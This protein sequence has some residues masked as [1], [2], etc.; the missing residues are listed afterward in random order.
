MTTL[1]LLAA[2]AAGPPNIVL[3]I[4]DDLGYGELS[5]DR[6]HPVETPHLSRLIDD[7]VYFTGGYV[8]APFCAASRA[9]L[10]TGRYQ[11]RFG[12]EFNPIGP[13]NERPGVGLPPAEV[14]IPEML[15]R[16]GYAT[17]LIGKWHLGGAAEY[18]PQRHGFDRFFGFLHEGHFYVPRGGPDVFTVVRREV[19]PPGATGDLWVDAD[20]GLALHT[21]A[22]GH[23]PPYDANNPILDGGQPVVERQYLTDAFAREAAAFI[24]RHAGRPFFLSVAFNAVHSPMQSRRDRMPDGDQMDIQRRV[25]VGMLR[26][27]DEAVG[28]VVA[29]LEDAGVAEETLIVFLSDNGGPEA[30]LTSDNGPL[31]G[32]KGDVYEGGVR[33]PFVVRW[34]GRSRAGTVVDT[35]VIATDLFETFRVAAGVEAEGVTR[36]GVSLQA[37]CTGVSPD[38]SLFWRLGKKAALRRGDW[39]IVRQPGSDGW[40]L[41]NLADD[42]AEASPVEDAG[43]RD[44]LVR[45]WERTNGEM[46]EPLWR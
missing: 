15:R 31:R 37:V 42:I 17:G 13:K 10:M 22:R 34:P 3:L 41:F 26:S 33:V 23:E 7:G 18:H 9:G 39:K 46:V 16:G 4:A 12:F 35:P 21:R 2:A 29:A 45:E 38:R 5:P 36:D 14:T 44:E 25:F 27:M 20:A 30:E 43:R 19:L 6:S 8:T 24:D 40:E 1:L 32:G 28:R 11:T